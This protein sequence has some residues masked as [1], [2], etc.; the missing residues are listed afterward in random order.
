MYRQAKSEPTPE[1]V[2]VKFLPPASA[3]TKKWFQLLLRAWNV[4][5][6]CW[7]FSASP[8]SWES[9]FTSGM[10]FHVPTDSGAIRLP[11]VLLRTPVNTISAERYCE[12][13]IT[14]Y[15]CIVK[16]KQTLGVFHYIYRLTQHLHMNEH[17]MWVLYLCSQNGG[18]SFN[19]ELPPGTQTSKSL[20]LMQKQK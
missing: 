13:D 18:V 17:W 7:R 9:P 2:P 1:G 14:R 12:A 20:T 10:T 4:P 3:A 19:T 5:N 11:F 6:I 15:I 16:E 8:T